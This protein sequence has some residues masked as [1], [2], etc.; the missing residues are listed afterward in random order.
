MFKKLLIANR[1]EIAIRI[2]RTAADRGLA[3][4]AMYTADD[5]ASLHLQYADEAA[6]LPGSG[7][8]GYLDV[9][10]IV[11]IAKEHGCD[12]I[13]PGYGLLSE[14]ADFA[15]ACADVGIVF[16]GPAPETLRANGDKVAARALAETAGVPVIPGQNDITSPDDITE[17]FDLHGGRP[18]MVKAVN[19]G[20]GRG[21]RVVRHRADIVSAFDACTAESQSAFGSSA[22]YA[23]R[24]LPHV[25][26]I[27]V[28]IVGDGQDVIH[29]F[30]RDCSVQR[31]NQKVVEVAPAPHLPQGVRDRLAADAVRI[32]RSCQYK[33]LGTVEFL[34]DTETGEHVFIETNPRIQVE[35]TITE[36]ITGLDLVSIQLDLAAG[37]SLTELGLRQEEIKRR[38]GYAIQLRVNAETASND[39]TIT[40]SSG[41]ITDYLPASGPGVR[42][43]TFIYPGYATNP[44]FDNL[45][46]KLIIRSGS[47][48]FA[49]ALAKADRALSEMRIDGLPTNLELLRSFVTTE[50][51]SAWDGD[52][53]AYESILRSSVHPNSDAQ[54]RQP[55]ARASNTQATFA[56]NSIDVPEGQQAVRSPMHA[57]VHAVLVREGQ[58]FAAGDELAIVEAMKM[59]H[60]VR[61]ESGG[62]VQ[63]IHAAAGDT[64]HTDQVLLI[65][66][67]SNAD[68][69]GEEAAATVDLDQIRPDLAALQERVGFTLDE[70]RPD[71]LA[72]RH[73]RGQRTARENIAD[74]IEPDSLVEYGQLTYAAQRTKYPRE[75]LMKRSPGD[76][77]V[78]GIAS[79]RT[80][81]G[82]GSG[83]DIAIL[84]YDGSVFAGTQGAFGHQKTDRLF[85]VAAELD[86]PI[87]FLA[88]GGGGRPNDVDFQEIIRSGLGVTT[89]HHFA[90][91]K[92]SA[93]NVTMVS[94]FCFAGNAAVFGA[95]DIK[96]A[97]RNA[98]IG[99]GGPAMI[100]G[101]GLGVVEPTDIGPAPM[102]AEIGLIDILVDDDAEACAAVRDVMTYFG[103]R[104]ETWEAGDA[105][106]L[107]HTVPENRKRIYDMRALITDL[108]DTDGFLELRRQFGLG[109]IT[110]L[111]RIEGHT[112][113]LIANNPGH[114][115]G[116]VDAAASKKAAEFLTFCERFKLPVLSLCDTPGF[117]VGL[118]SEEE[119]G[120]KEACGFL[121]A[122]AEL[123]T[124]LIFI[125]I[126][127]GYGIGAQAMAGGTF[128]KPVANF[129][130][131]TGEFGPMGLEGSVRLGFK[132]ELEAAPTPEAQNELFEQ[133]VAHMYKEGHAL[134]VA[135][136][137]EIDGVIDPA[138][139]R[140]TVVRVLSSYSNHVHDLS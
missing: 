46:A 61:A 50:G 106:A 14:R 107:R 20:G 101:G 123:T 52:V 74:I 47:E 16:V 103:G 59:Q 54:L 100:E 75:D 42:V 72:R 124:P 34:L 17:F 105:R 78:A 113:G 82:S 30:E 127:K 40:P 112:M 95:G 86:V 87:V 73:G 92:S 67:T 84:A 64:V 41:T 138:D 48:D 58:A 22:L 19:G 130:W 99:L 44:H 65:A 2:A 62:V 57:V 60:A 102:Q 71:A 83:Q 29:L 26:H 81:Q 37:R 3:T 96:I 121:R 18:V 39:G 91:H 15:E 49:D 85:D 120:V 11:R 104:S 4:L 134:N 109:M 80:E 119:G 140:K 97:T 117:M 89:F 12:A 24:F 111:I 122:G 38:S 25:R 27:E 131:P 66:L 45:L 43:D 51:L 108:A 126:R 8:A 115:G 13:H 28:Q 128:V 53:A 129:A 136:L 36:E 31:R 32:G 21:M 23:E 68:G 118:T 133:M 6:E 76:G 5:Q 94:G 10:A 56:S 7:V 35:H 55:A 70:N 135:S 132:R 79:V 69:G 125:C 77:V 114:L 137:L 88:E 93:P 90:R 63:T 9:A 98:W 1:G 110:G 33:G 116:A 139:T